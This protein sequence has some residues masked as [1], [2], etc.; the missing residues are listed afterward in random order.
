M[1]EP[2]PDPTRFTA[3]QRR[4]LVIARSDQDQQR[5]QCKAADQHLGEDPHHRKIHLMPPGMFRLQQLRCGDGRTAVEHRRRYWRRWCSRPPCGAS[6]RPDV[7]PRAHRQTLPDSARQIPRPSLLDACLPT[8]PHPAGR[9]PL[10]PAR[11]R[12]SFRVQDALVSPPSGSRARRRYAAPDLPHRHRRGPRVA[13]EPL[14]RRRRPP[15]APRHRPVTV[16]HR[17]GDDFAGGQL[18]V[19]QTRRRQP[20]HQRGQPLTYDTHRLRLRR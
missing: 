7:P 13:A 2:C 18:D 14:H 10:V 11:T 4:R 9:S 20:C 3:V 8:P 17:I 15:S 5:A 12:P 19:V 6:N 1:P 16:E